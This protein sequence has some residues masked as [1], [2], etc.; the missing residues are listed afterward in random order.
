MSGCLFQMELNGV[1]WLIKI[2]CLTNDHCAWNLFLI[3]CKKVLCMYNKIFL[4]F[5][6]IQSRCMLMDILIQL[7]HDKM[8]MSFF[9]DEHLIPV[10][11]INF[12]SKW[13]HNVCHVIIF[14]FYN[15]KID[16]RHQY[17]QGLKVFLFFCRKPISIIVKSFLIEF[18]ITKQKKKKIP[19]VIDINL[20]QANCEDGK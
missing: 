3:F 12:Q 7:V 13:L 16:K 4:K 18:L 10:S 11:F 1:L 5:P 2:F 19:K 6:K 14:N 9:C 20:T 17:N 8:C 15:L